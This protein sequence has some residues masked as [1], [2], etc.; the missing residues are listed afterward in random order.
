[1]AVNS[2]VQKLIRFLKADDGP[3]AVEYVLI[4]SLIFLVAIAGIKVFGEATGRSFQESNDTMSS[5][6]TGGN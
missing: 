4:L 1:V 2:H 6:L 3:T 5:F